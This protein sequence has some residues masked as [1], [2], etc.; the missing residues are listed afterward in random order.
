MHVVKPCVPKSKCQGGAEASTGM[1]E[2]DYFRNLCH[3]VLLDRKQQYCFA[4]LELSEH[5][6]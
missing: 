5:T 3:S 4:F 6:H 2:F 1:S